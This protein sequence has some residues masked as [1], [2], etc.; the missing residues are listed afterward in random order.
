MK[1]CD[2]MYYSKESISNPNCASLLN[3]LIKLKQL[4]N[5]SD[6]VSVLLE[7]GI[8]ANAIILTN[9]EV[10]SWEIRGKLLAKINR[11]PLQSISSISTEGTLLKK[12]KIG[13]SGMSDIK[14]DLIENGIDVDKL[15]Q[16]FLELKKSAA[17]PTTNNDNVADQI[18]K[19]FDLKEQGI[20]TEE[21]F[22]LKKK[23]L[24]DI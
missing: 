8:S 9:N 16:D 24:L 19:L 5:I 2:S 18:K 17:N 7:K 13:M 21:E 22:E 12:I 6:V 4:N 23:K 10:I 1:G 3:K 15:Y 11:Y 20:L 14:F